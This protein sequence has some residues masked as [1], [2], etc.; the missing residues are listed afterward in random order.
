MF[1]EET[2]DWAFKHHDLVFQCPAGSISWV[3]KMWQ[4]LC[5][6]K[7][8][9]QYDFLNVAVTSDL[10]ELSQHVLW[11]SE[12]RLLKISAIL[13]DHK[14]PNYALIN[15]AIATNTVGRN[16]T[17][18]NNYSLIGILRTWPMLNAW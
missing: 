4:F 5:V 9:T 12:K 11:V 1:W 8:L 13:W 6:L 2:L 7:W 17:K 14:I 16:G 15:C 18:R 10:K 3:L